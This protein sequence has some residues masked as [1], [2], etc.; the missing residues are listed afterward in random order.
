MERLMDLFAARLG[1]DGAV[2]DRLLAWE[3]D[4]TS[5]GHSVPPR[6]V[7]ALHGLVLDGAAPDLAPDL[8]AIYPPQGATDDTLWHAVAAAMIPHQDR[9]M[10]WLDKA[11]QTNEVRRAAA[12]S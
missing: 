10:T 8:A 7:G 2:A 9:V 3:G 11:P 4:V 6:I 1:A 12:L 5:A